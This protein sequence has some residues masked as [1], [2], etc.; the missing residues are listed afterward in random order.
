MLTSPADELADIRA[1]IQRLKRREAELRAAFLTRADMPT[2]GRWYKVELVTQRAQIFDPRLLPD[3][4]RHDPAY[5]REKV[6]RVLKS[7]RRGPRP[8]LPELA[9]VHQA[10]PIVAAMRAPAPRTRFLGAL[11]AH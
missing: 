2:V 5:S 7:S 11:A 10:D 1:E 8:V 4:I 9:P 3:A 6:T